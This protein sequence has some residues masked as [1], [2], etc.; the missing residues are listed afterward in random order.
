M[1]CQLEFLSLFLC[2]DYTICARVERKNFI[3]TLESA[4]LFPG[5]DVFFIGLHDIGTEQ[6]GSSWRAGELHSAP[7]IIHNMAVRVREQAI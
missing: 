1:A 7:V 4:D 2:Y 3:K 5:D 6:T